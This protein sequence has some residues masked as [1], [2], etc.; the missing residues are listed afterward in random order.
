MSACL[1]TEQLKLRDW[2][3]FVQLNRT[4]LIGSSGAI[5]QNA[6]TMAGV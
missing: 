5:Q 6:R 2:Q 4:N 3:I 1:V